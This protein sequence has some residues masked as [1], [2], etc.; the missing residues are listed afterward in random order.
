MQEDHGAGTPEV[1]ADVAPEATIVEQDAILTTDANDPESEANDTAANTL[2][3]KLKSENQS[4]RKR[5]REIESQLKER[6]EAELSESERIRRRMI[7]LE[8]QVT[9]K[10]QAA[11]DA[12]LR[13]E[14]AANASTLGIVDVDAATRLLDTSVLEYDSDSDEWMGVQDALRDLSQQRPW[15]V[16]TAQSVASGANPTNPPMRRTRITRESLA[17]MTD[18]EIK[19]LPWE[20]VEAALTSK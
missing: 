1:L 2:D 11:R 9:K 4:L 19:N 10:D 12:R 3:R 20:E 6:E 8:E 16:T 7:E 14:I 18:A 15:L 13:A 17:K 5:L